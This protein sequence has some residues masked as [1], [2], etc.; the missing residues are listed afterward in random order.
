MVCDK[1]NKK[2]RQ[3]QISTQVRIASPISDFELSM[4]LKVRKEFRSRRHKNITVRSIG[5][6]SRI[7]L[8]D[9]IEFNFF[10]NICSVTYPLK[11]F[12]LSYESNSFTK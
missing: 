4:G 7:N 5:R 3:L 1:S 12:F 11:Y 8:Y 10:L 2:T 6:D 9:D